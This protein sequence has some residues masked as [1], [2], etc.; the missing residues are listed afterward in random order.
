MDWKETWRDDQGSL[1]SET[2][3]TGEASRP[4]ILTGDPIFVEW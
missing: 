3:F 2:V 1:G 4:Q